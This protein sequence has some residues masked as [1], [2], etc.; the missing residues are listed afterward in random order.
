MRYFDGTQLLKEA[1]ESD[2]TNTTARTAYAT[3]LV[4]D[5]RG[6]ELKTIFKD[7]PEVYE[8]AEI[9][10]AYAQIKQYDKAIALYKKLIAA[11]PKNLQLRS[12]LAQ[13]QYA[14]GMKWQAIE[15]LTGL[16]RIRS[17]GCISLLNLFGR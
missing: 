5:G 7:M 17:A 4:I 11:D 14:A 12:T 3:A 2:T 13:V 6:D 15:T 1:Y 8:S 9:A 16:R 10:Q